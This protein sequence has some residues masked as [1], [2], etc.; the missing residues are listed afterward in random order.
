MQGAA[1]AADQVAATGRKDVS[2]AL[3]HETRAVA[4]DDTGAAHVNP[5][6]GR[7]KR[8]LHVSYATGDEISG[9]LGD[10][11]SAALGDNCSAI[12]IDV[13]STASKEIAAA[14]RDD[15]TTALGDDI[16]TTLRDDVAATGRDDVAAALG[17]D[18][19]AALGNDALD[20][21][22]TD[23]SAV[24]AD[25]RRTIVADQ[26][27]GS[28][29]VEIAVVAIAA[30]RMEHGQRSG[31]V[32]EHPSAV[33]SGAVEGDQIAGA[34]GESVSAIRRQDVAVEDILSGCDDHSVAQWNDDRAI[35]IE[36]GAIDRNEV[37]VCANVKGSLVREDGSTVREDSDEQIFGDACVSGQG[38]DES[39]VIF[40]DMGGSFADNSFV[41]PGGPIR[42]RHGYCR[43][44][45]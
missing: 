41:G 44:G 35:I 37:G 8:Q 11:I 6:G 20:R 27:A 15:V 9:T 22:D 13:S 5:H 28:D 12:G 34:G 39:H 30:V 29:V 24:V 43:M 2:A 3:G 10:N 7:Q 4:V 33:V 31:K 25:Q 40:I 42:G 45:E 21:A 19:A 26:V 36:R 23:P 38:T 16:A 1:A 18:V 32:V 17:N 14:L